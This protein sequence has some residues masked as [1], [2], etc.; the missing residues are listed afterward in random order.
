MA[1]CR[2][3]QRYQVSIADVCLAAGMQMAFLRKIDKILEGTVVKS[4]LRRNRI[5]CLCVFT[6]ICLPIWDEAYRIPGKMSGAKAF[7]TAE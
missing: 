7:R 2:G 4:F 6:D 5:R 1:D 3:G